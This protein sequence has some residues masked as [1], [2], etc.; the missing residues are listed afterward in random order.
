MNTTNLKVLIN[1]LVEITLA[2][3]SLGGVA[4]TTTV[5]TPSVT[6]PSAPPTRTL[7]SGINPSEFVWNYLNHHYETQI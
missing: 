2:S 4:T 3:G 5:T 1:R 7:P 6:K